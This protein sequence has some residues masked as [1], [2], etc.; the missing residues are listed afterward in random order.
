[1]DALPFRSETLHQKEMLAES[2]KKNEEKDR[3]E[4]VYFFFDISSGGRFKPFGGES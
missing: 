2:R 4:I 1:M 3:H